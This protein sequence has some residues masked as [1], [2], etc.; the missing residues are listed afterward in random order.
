MVGS[1]TGKHQLQCL[2]QSEEAQLSASI[3]QA[4]L[5]LLRLTTITCTQKAISC[6]EQ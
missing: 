5:A 4:K 1:C 3:K 6:K 2:S